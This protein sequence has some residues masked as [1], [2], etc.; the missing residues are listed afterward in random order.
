MKIALTGLPASAG[1]KYPAELS[2]GM[3]KRA[4]LAR[5]IALDPTLLFLD[6]PTAGPRS[7][8]RRRLRRA[9]EAPEGAARPDDLHGHP[10]S[11]SA[12]ARGRPRGLH[13]GG[14]DRRRRHDA[15]SSRD[16]RSRWS[17]S[18]STGR[19]AAGPGSRHGNQGELRAG[20]RLRA[21]AVARYRGRRAV[22][23]LGRDEAQGLRHL[24]GLLR[25]SRSRA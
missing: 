8:Q 13:G 5:A 22:D 21:D 11:R 17:G 1:P 18:T 3:R 7:A 15:A 6:E 20:G 9:G 16:R 19:A 4:A 25:A 12:L 2:G 23:L 14:A 10:R 24:P